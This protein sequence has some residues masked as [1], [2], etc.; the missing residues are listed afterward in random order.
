MYNIS[1][2]SLLR[3]EIFPDADELSARLGAPVADPDENISRVINEIAEVASPAFVATRV[4]ILAAENGRVIIDG[5]SADSS[6]LCKYFKGCGEAHLFVV[7][8][9][10]GV[11][12]LIMKMR[13]RSL[14]DGFLYD[15]V[16]SAMA[17]AA[18]DSA[19]K[20]ITRGER[21]KHRFSPGYA[22]SELSIQRDIFRILDVTRNI[23]VCLLDSCLM[24]P[25]KSISAFIATEE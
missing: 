22:D 21:V 11:D 5:F 15:A 1:R 14:S 10:A 8:L 3:S 2:G 24:S 23:G 16:A 20:H 17:E 4:K 7:T 6:A 19:E 18:A 9:G 12:R 25:M 13:A